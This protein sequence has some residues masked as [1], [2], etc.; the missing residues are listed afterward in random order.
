MNTYDQKNA[1]H[2]HH[3]LIPQAHRYR[4]PAR[5]KAG[6]IL[7]IGP[8]FGLAAALS[9]PAPSRSPVRLAAITALIWSESFIAALPARGAMAAT[10]LV[11]TVEELP[12]YE[13]FL[14]GAP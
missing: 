11:L 9:V 10:D 14:G 5:A 8:E 7:V 6:W 13:A 12:P 2:D 3:L 1:R 4:S